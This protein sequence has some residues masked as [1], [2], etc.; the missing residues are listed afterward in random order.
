MDAKGVPEDSLPL[1]AGELPE[2]RCLVGDGVVD[3][4]FVDSFLDGLVNDFVLL[5]DEILNSCSGRQVDI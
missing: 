5:G 1:S 2:F 3:G 4:M